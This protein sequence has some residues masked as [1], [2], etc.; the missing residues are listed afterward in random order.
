MP[1]TAVTVVTPA[2]NAGTAPTTTNLDPT[3][4]HSITVGKK[5]RLLVRINSTF[6][7]AKTFTF[8]AGANPPASRAGLGDLVVSINNAVRWVVLESARFKQTDGAIYLDVESAATGTV[9]AVALPD[10]AG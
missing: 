6:A 8:K 2:V 7:G 4:G 3:N 5:R 1:R 10:G 9:E